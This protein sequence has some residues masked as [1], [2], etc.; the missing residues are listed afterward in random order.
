MAGAVMGRRR[1]IL[2]VIIPGR[3]DRGAGGAPQTV[4]IFLRP[5]V[6]VARP[7]T[8]EQ[9]HR[10]ARDRNEP[11]HVS[12]QIIPLPPA[13]TITGTHEVQQEKPAGQIPRA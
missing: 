5:G 1:L 2:R 4:E 11:L 6:R 8:G 12:A 10:Q 13:V 7:V 3:S 9:Q